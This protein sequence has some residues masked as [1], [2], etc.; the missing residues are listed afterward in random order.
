MILPAMT[1]GIKT[2]RADPDSLHHPQVLKMRP[3]VKS[4]YCK[5]LLILTTSQ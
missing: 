5:R 4:Y 2:K 1:A 3:E